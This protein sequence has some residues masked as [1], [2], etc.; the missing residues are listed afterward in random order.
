[1][2]INIDFQMNEEISDE[3]IINSIIRVIKPRRRAIAE[4]QIRH[5]IN[6]IITHP[7]KK[8]HYIKK[9]RD[10]VLYEKIRGVNS[11]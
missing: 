4:R 1:M 9:I 11:D 10:L 6:K 8:S 7:E 3:I 5:H 2:N